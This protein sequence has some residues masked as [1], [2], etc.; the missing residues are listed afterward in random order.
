LQ[1]P[2]A[3]HLLLGLLR[4]PEGIAAQLFMGFGVYPPTFR[5]Q[6]L[7]IMGIPEQPVVNVA[8][9]WAPLRQTV[10]NLNRQISRLRWDQEDALT[11]HQLQRAAAVQAEI[12]KL[13]AENQTIFARHRADERIQELP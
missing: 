2:P 3:E 9:W 7:A 8:E 1:R 13:E 5:T 6:L 12:M 4:E 10:Q 11:N